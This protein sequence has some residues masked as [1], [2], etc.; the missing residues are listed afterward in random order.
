[1]E[2]IVSQVTFCHQHSVNSCRPGS[3]KPAALNL[4][5][6]DTRSQTMK[7][8]FAAV[9]ST[10]LVSTAFA[11]TAAP[12]MSSGQQQTQAAGEANLKAGTAAQ[13]DAA[14]ADAKTKQVSATPGNADAKAEAKADTKTDAKKPAAV[15]TQKTQAHKVSKKTHSV[16]A[17]A[18][19]T[20]TKADA[21][22]Q[23]SKEANSTAAKTDGAKADTTQ[24]N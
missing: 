5:S 18:H 16:V 6:R 3:V 22:K 19:D 15:H 4:F 9:A 24:T 17:S 1:L 13:P 20:K 10:L 21:S 11:Q 23:D 14:K 12:A 2:S 7:K 8:I